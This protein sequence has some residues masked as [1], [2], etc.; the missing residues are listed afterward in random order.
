MLARA[1]AQ[2]VFRA[3]VGFRALRPD[4]A[5]AGVAAAVVA[6][7]LAV[8]IR[9]GLAVDACVARFTADDVDGIDDAVA[10]VCDVSVAA[11]VHSAC[12]L[13]ALGAGA[14]LAALA[15]RLNDH[16]D[17]DDAP[18]GGG[19]RAALNAPPSP[20]SPP[21]PPPPSSSSAEDAWVVGAI[22]LVGATDVLIPVVLVPAV[23]GA[24][25][26]ARRRR[27]LAGAVFATFVALLRGVVQARDT[28]FRRVASLAPNDT[29]PRGAATPIVVADGR[30]RTKDFDCRR[31]RAGTTTVQMTRFFG[32]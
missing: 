20:S 21:P 9:R 18:R 3:R 8:R 10:P 31:F 23:V 17:D 25:A 1:L 26:Y 13:A 16:D 29:A 24:V 12:L 28:K 4:L 15:A 14:A 30:S 19:S 6:A 22:A 5:A 27:A 2:R 7:P 11:L 32:C